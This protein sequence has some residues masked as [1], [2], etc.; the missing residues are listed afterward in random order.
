MSI[1]TINLFCVPLMHS[2][3]S[4]TPCLQLFS[5]AVSLA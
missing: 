5:I 1:F 2:K 3:A 4:T